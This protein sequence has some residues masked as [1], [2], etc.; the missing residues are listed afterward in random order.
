[1]RAQT[2]RP[3][4]R[5]LDRRAFNQ[6]TTWPS[7]TL[8]VGDKG[9]GKSTK[10][11]ERA[12]YCFEKG[13]IVIDLVDFGRFENAFYALEG[14]G[15]NRRVYRSYKNLWRT[16]RPNVEVKEPIPRSFPT[17]VL[18]PAVSG[19]DEQL[20][21]IFKPF[22]IPFSEMSFEELLILL[23]NSITERGKQL[24][25]ASW[26]ML[27]NK[28][29]RSI[30]SLITVVKEISKKGRIMFDGDALPIANLSIG[31]PVLRAL[32]QLNKTGLICADDD[33]FRIDLDAM[34]HDKSQIHSFTMA[35]L[36]EIEYQYVIY[37]WLCKKIYTLRMR[38]D[39]PE[40][41]LIMREVQKLA[42][43]KNKYE[44]QN[45]S[46]KYLTELAS[47][48]RDL[49]LRMYY[50]TQHPNKIDK[51]LRFLPQIYH[52]FRMDRGPLDDMANAIKLHASVVS[53]TQKYPRGLATSKNGRRV[54]C[55]M[56]YAPPRSWMKQPTNDFIKIW[57]RKG[58]P[59]THVKTG[60]GDQSTIS[61]KIMEGEDEH[62]Q[63]RT[64]V[65]I[66]DIRK[67]SILK[68]ISTL[69]RASKKD[70]MQYVDIGDSQLN[71]LLSDL[72]NKERKLNITIGGYRNRSNLYSINEEKE[73]NGEST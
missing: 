72:A 54:V 22:R 52:L 23:G 12:E 71:D 63:P 64:Q 14:E 69:K 11:K 5:G 16:L 60:D 73:N 38:G 30:K 20:P 35:F 47:E 10:L 17:E 26:L 51:E 59:M 45:I 53:A 7:D 49:N 13:R 19:I 46:R 24:L 57:R 41:A 55:Y 6:E 70:I 40:M 37:G 9:T 34:M 68:V 29:D 56:S 27:D 3:R 50:D 36:P 43:S 18:F 28:K 4:Y 8:I 61:I 25:N 62:S 21:A 44:G 58:L 65:K 2:L 39:Y 1:M 48:G 31:V 32:T 42:P 67:A 15:A 33:P 66:T